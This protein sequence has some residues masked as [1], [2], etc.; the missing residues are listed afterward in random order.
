MT[1]CAFRSESI[2]KGA[3]VV[4]NNPVSWSKRDLHCIL[5]TGFI[6]YKNIVQTR[7]DSNYQSYLD[8]EDLRQILFI[9]VGG[10]GVTY[11]IDPWTFSG[12]TNN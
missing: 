6:Y 1:A 9:E 7:H 10:R 5:K 12:D 4:T 8:L 11:T 3:I 2:E